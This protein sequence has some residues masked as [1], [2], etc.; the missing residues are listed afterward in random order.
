M[1]RFERTE[2]GGIDLVTDRFR[3]D[4]KAHGWMDL[5]PDLT[6]ALADE[7]GLRRCPVDDSVDGVNRLHEAL[8]QI[9]PPAAE[10]L[11]LLLAQDP[12]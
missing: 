4:L 11:A 6:D 12:R 10:S 2:D 9:D 5:L 7:D 3:A 8:E 1:L